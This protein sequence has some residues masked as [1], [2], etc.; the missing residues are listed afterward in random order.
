MEKKF[1]ERERETIC[2]MLKSAR[3]W[4][5]N[6][7]SA[8]MRTV[9]ILRT[10]AKGQAW[11]HNARNP[12]A[13]RMVLQGQLGSVGHQLYSGFSERLSLKG[14]HFCTHTWVSRCTHLP[15]HIHV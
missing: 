13:N 1:T 2:S 6:T 11:A 4:G 15:T 7:Y 8:I 3:D 9:Q 10:H 12:S 14:T 5:E